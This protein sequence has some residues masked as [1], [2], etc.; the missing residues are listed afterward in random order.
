MEAAVVPIEEELGAAFKVHFVSAVDEPRVIRNDGAAADVQ[1]HQGQR[2]RDLG[3]GHRAFEA[4]ALQ[5]SILSP[6]GRYTLRTPAAFRMG[7]TRNE[8]PQ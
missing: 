7:A 8:P 3:Q 6:A 1:R 2:L 4:L 5:K